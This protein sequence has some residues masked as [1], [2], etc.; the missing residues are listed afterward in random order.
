MKSLSIAIAAATLT[1]AATGARAADAV[2][3]VGDST[4]VRIDLATGKAGKPI[5]VTGAGRL[6][7]IDVRPANKM[8][9]GVAVD[10]AVVTIDP[11]TGKASKVAQLDTLLPGAPTWAI[12]DFNP[13][14]D[15]LRF[16]GSDGT[17]LR[18]D[19]DTGKVVKDGNLA[20]EKGDKNE[21]QKPSVVAAA[22]SNSLGKPQ[23][24]AMY[25]I[26]KTLGALVHQTKPNDGLLKVIGALGTPKADVIA[27]DIS[28]T[29]DGTN[30]AWLAAD[31]AIFKVAIDSGKATSVGKAT[32]IEGTIRDIA[33]LQN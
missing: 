5:T 21:G 31:N 19:V 23:A 9:Y 3:L 25:D 2:A 12:V 13:A 6:L 16:V 33:V 10:G 7:G 26:D 14:A 18:A 28:T 17:N 15:K 27:F 20:F 4:L 32:G 24:T 8:L 11:A 22:Y 1:L 29:A 30:T